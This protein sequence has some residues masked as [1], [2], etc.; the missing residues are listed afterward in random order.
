MPSLASLLVQETEAQIYARALAVATSL[1]LPV[2]AWSAGN[3]TRSL[4]WFL[5]KV[6]S[7][8]E[9]NVAGFV[10]SGFLDYATGDWLT[11]LASE[12]FN[13]TRNPATYATATVLLSNGGGGLFTLNPGDV[14]VKDT[15]TGQ[16]YT[17][18]SGGTLASGPGPQLSITVI[19]DAAGSTSSAA[20]GTIDALVTGLVGVTCSNT[21]AAVGSDAEL[22]ADLR[23]RCRGKLA[24]ASPNGP[25]GAYDY[26][27]RTTALT[28]SSEITRS[29]TIHDSTTG[30]VTVYV[31]GGSGAVSGGAVTA[32]QTAVNANCTPLCITPVVTNCTATSIPIAYTLWLYTSVGQTSAQIQSAVTSALTAWF[33]ARPIGGDII[34]PATTGAVYQSM[35]AS[36][37][38]EVFPNDTFRVLVTTPSSDTALAINAVPILYGTPTATINLVAAP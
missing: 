29:R 13:V 1:G 16:T 26:V 21:T 31:A 2:T 30:I 32:A 9:A 23:S 4:Y 12:V 33:A 17:S 11:L 20:V 25:T 22:D 36:V 37:I 19:A 15:A 24:L 38:A 14:R 18:T 35:I 6:L 8:L 27:V 34:P 5:T 28:G 3:P 7:S 10:A